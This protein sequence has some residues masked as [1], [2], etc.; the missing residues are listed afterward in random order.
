MAF[1]RNYKPV[2]L[3]AFKGKFNRQRA[4]C[5]RFVTSQERTFKSIHI[6]NWQILVWRF[7]KGSS[8]FARVRVLQK[9][10]FGEPADDFWNSWKSASKILLQKWILKRGAQLLSKIGA[11]SSRFRDR[12]SWTVA[13]IHIKEVK[14]ILQVINGSSSLMCSLLW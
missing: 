6:W 11:H 8:G 7:L 4:E 12:S 1:I 5:V 10:V 2:Y 9:H 3:P 13:R 14:H